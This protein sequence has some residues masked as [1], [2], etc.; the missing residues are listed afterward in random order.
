VISEPEQR[1]LAEIEMVL[2]RDDP[3]FVRHFDKRSFTP[4]RAYLWAILAILVVSAVTAVAATLGGA[5]A[6][7]IVLS[8]ISSIAIP[9]GLW[10]YRAQRSKRAR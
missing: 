8:V 4:R 1:R 3:A 7:G 9:F 10:R 6:A 5:G 2:R